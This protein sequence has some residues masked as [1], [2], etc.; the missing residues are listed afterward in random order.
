MKEIQKA[1]KFRIYPNAEQRQNLVQT[2]GS[3]RF[4]YNWALA[5]RKE[6]Y[7]NG[8]KLKNND[9]SQMLTQLKKQTETEWLNNVS[10]VCLQQSLANLDA[11]YQN[12]FKGRASFPC[13]KKKSDKQA[14]KYV[15]SAFTFSGGKLKLA[16]HKQPIKMKQSRTFTGEITSLVVSKTCDDKFFVSLLV[17]EQYNSKPARSAKQLGIDLGIKD[18]ATYSDGTKVANPNHYRKS[19][20][21]LKKLQQALSKK[22]RGSGN[23]KKLKLRIA[24]LH[25]S[26]SNKRTDFLQK[27]STQIINENQVICVEDLKVSKMLKNKR[28]AKLAG[29]LGWNSFVNMIS[30]KCSWNDRTFIK[31]DQFYPSSKTCHVCGFVKNDLKLHHRSWCCPQCGTNH[32]RD[33]N[34]AMNILA[35]G[36]TAVH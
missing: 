5:Q 13:F 15:K 14:A 32:D 16:K 27:L 33:V 35:V 25:A 21:K 36:L 30:Y 4:V 1:Y 10:S 26:V 19:L 3:A 17:K 9:V 7:A 22:Q 24:R 29:S 20:R 31:I 28:I 11:A 12:F 2:M 34:A 8:I 18:F 23:Y 6:A